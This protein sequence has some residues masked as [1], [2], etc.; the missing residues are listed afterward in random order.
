MDFMRRYNAAECAALVKLMDALEGK[1]NQVGVYLKSYH[2]AGAIASDFLRE[3]GAR[4]H[5]PHKVPKRVH[6]WRFMSYFG[7]RIELCKRG[8]YERAA[9]GGP[10]G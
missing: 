8:V 9:A 2:G 3:I 1:L 5:Y 10:A 4:K 6:Y 7:G